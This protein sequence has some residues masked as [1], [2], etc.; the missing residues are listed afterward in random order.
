M[1]EIIYW[2]NKRSQF[3]VSTIIGNRIIVKMRKISHDFI[4]TL[5]IKS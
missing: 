4:N 3:F 1:I 2:Y 5:F